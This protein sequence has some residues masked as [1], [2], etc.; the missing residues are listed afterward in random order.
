MTGPQVDYAAVFRDL[1]IPVL[2]LTPEFVIADM[3]LAYLQ[4]AGR[5]R[6]EL[7]GRNVFDVFPDNPSD[8]G[9]TGVRRLSVS[10]ARVLATSQPD[11]ISLQ[12]YD[13]EVP[14]SP[15]L[16]AK[17]YWSP[18][19][20]P[21]FGPDGRVEMIVLCVEEITQRVSKFIAGLADSDAQ[22]AAPRAGDDD[23]DRRAG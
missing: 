21:V 5:R 1:P 7:V 15:G 19:N 9:A 13:V 14:G 16:F 22:L 17:R 2:L 8:P 23:R 4:V 10:L 20:A 11:A 12:Q 18:V 3:N 6:E